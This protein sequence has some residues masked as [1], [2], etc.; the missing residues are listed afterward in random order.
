MINAGVVGLDPPTLRT[1]S[2][3]L[4]NLAKSSDPRL[5]LTLR[6]QDPIPDWITHVIYLFPSLQVAH[7][8]RTDDVIRNLRDES[9]PNLI[10][11]GPQATLEL[12]RKLSARGIE[13]NHL[14]RG[15]SAK[16]DA[17]TP[18][19]VTA[20]GKDSAGATQ[21][22]LEMENVQVRY[23]DKQVLGGWVEE[24]DGQ[25]RQGLWWTVRRGQRWGVFGPNGKCC[26]LVS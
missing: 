2:P 7:Q 24:V 22:V 15:V 21:P 18:S 3:L 19:V 20:K 9:K 14:N 23:G 4:Y 12:G 6:P 26:H 11:Q 13:D 10:R 5:L 17:Q 16:P 8:G 25:P 1:L